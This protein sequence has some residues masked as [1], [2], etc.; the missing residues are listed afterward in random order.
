[1]IGHII[2]KIVETLQGFPAWA[3]LVMAFLLPALEAS[4]F[5]GVVIPGEIALLLA[6]VA[7]RHGSLPLWSVIVAGVLGAVIGDFIGFE[8]G[9]RWGQQLLD[10]LPKRIVKPDH[11]ER[12]RAALRKRGAFTVFFGRWAAAL[13]A[14]VPGLAGMSGMR[15]RVFAPANAAGGSVWAIVVAVLGYALASALEK[16][17]HALGAVSS[18]ITALVICASLL[19]AGMS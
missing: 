14:F 1:M 13:R 19:L 7:A 15:L 5:L 4:V 17:E 10:K 9:R 12:A 6:G 8:V 11:V 18:A 3:L 2:H 16:V